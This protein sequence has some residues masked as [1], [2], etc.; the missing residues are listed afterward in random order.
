MKQ[1]WFW[2]IAGMALLASVFGVATASQAA[3]LDLN[4][5]II[6][7][8]AP[9][10]AVVM[11][12]GTTL[13]SEALLQEAFYLDIESDGKALTLTNAFDDFTM[14]MQVGSTA[15]SFNGVAETLTSPVVERDGQIYF[16]LRA[17]MARFG[18]IEWYAESGRV[19]VRYDYNDQLALPLVQE[20]AVPLEY[21]LDQNAGV[22]AS[23]RDGRWPLGMTVD[24]MLY[25]LRDAQGQVTA[26]ATDAAVLIAPQH[27]VNVI[28]CYAVDEDFCYWIERP[29]ETLMSAA[30]LNWYLYIQERQPNAEPVCVAEGP[31]TSLQNG[32]LPVNAILGNADFCHGNIIWLHPEPDGVIQVR[33]YRHASGDTEILDSI[34]SQENR[35][36]EVALGERDAFWTNDYFFEMMREYGTM[37]RLDLETGT[38]TNFSQGYN[39]LTPCVVGDKLIVRMKP[40]GHNFMPIP[41]V[42]DKISSEL[43]VYDLTA[44]KWMFKIDNSLSAIGTENTIELPTVLDDHHIALNLGGTWGYKL[45]V[46]D[47]DEG[48]IY[49]TALD[50]QPGYKNETVGSIQP[51]DAERNNWAVMGHDENGQVSFTAYPLRFEW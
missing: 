42:P 51:M 47:L 50:Y 43:W 33:L 15:L 10:G 38:V 48:R 35:T 2:C 17:L 18:E 24:G 34:S 49:N 4:G 19:V 36:L 20:A 32:S 9:D 21:V 29:D 5:R 22:S 27:A 37:Y 46:V 45:P 28:Q 26:I 3:E 7:M 6:E 31:Y 1:K 25:E 39:L 14:Q 12:N 44:E 16:P 40:E 13:I 23:G 8:N 30:A 11:E 41:N